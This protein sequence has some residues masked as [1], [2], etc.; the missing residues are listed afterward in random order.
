MQKSA[1]RCSSMLVSCLERRR[2]VLLRS[3]QR[4]LGR[5]SIATLE[6][7][8]CA[9]CLRLRVQAGSL[10][11]GGMSVAFKYGRPPSSRASTG[12]VIA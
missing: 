11:H 10:E 4:I 1:K 3:Q 9:L 8:S 7:E 12:P 2:D 6:K 5:V